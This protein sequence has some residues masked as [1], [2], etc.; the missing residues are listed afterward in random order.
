MATLYN[1]SLVESGFPDKAKTGRVNPVHKSGRT[2]CIDNFRPISVLPIFSKVFEKVTLKR[3]E[4]FISRFDILSPCQFG[5]RSGR[6]TTQAITKLFSCILPAYHSKTY[7]ACFFLDLRKAF[8]T[9]DHKILM[10][11]LNH[12]GFRGNCYTFL[13]SYY[14]NRKQ[15][16]YLNGYES[17]MMVV[18]NGVPQGSIL[19]PLCFS[20]F[21]NDL[22][23]AVD[24]D[25]VLF[26]DDAAFV[27]KSSSLV[28]IYEDQQTLCRLVFLLE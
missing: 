19:G 2:D 18:T 23:L 7:C 26:A 12:Y 3:M 24:A 6:G 9:I 22:P 27:I 25:T 21:I 13:K 15:Y 1:F 5:F 14:Q 28:D 20:L 8:D 4:G 10:Q 16:V 17:D 11:K